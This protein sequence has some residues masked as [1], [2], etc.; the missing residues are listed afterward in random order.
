MDINWIY[1][2]C[3]TLDVDARRAAE[4]R[5]NTLT[6]PSGSLGELETIAQ[7]FAA[8]QGTD[9]PKCESILIRVFAA[10]HGVCQQGVS[11]FPQAVTAQMIANFVAG[12]AAISVLAKQ[13]NADFAAVNLGTI[14][15]CADAEQLINIQITDGTADFSQQAAMTS[16]QLALALNTGRQQV[17][18]NKADLFIAG[19]MG[20]GNTT[21]ASAL[22]SALLEQKPT[23]CVGPG[24]GVD[25]TVIDH[26]AKIIEQALTLHRVTSDQ[27]L[28]ILRCLGGLEIAAMTGAYICAAQYGCP[29]LVDGFI[30][31]AAA[32][33]A[34][35]IN[36]LCRNWMLFA[37]KS[38]E[39]A[40]H[41]ALK[42]LDAQ[43]LLDLRMR[44]G[45]GSGA[46]LVVSLLQ[47]SLALHNQMATFENSGVS[48]HA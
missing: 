35:K 37:H 6:K 33:L 47:S 23:A 5:Q 8:W 3:Q 4:T 17:I 39:P 14:E 12:G 25:T 29:I 30:S 48:D 32:L 13:L 45:E 9:R 2:A 41:L 42:Q 1:D 38:A 7:K 36:P 16:D 22:Y 21:T 34:V 15:P 27:P 43:P 28:D 44:L 46:A 40:H 11:A 10:D 31:T 26:K 18:D 19:D 24:T 20:I